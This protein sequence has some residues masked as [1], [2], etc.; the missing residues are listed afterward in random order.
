MTPKSISLRPI[1]INPIPSTSNAIPDT[2]E[3]TSEEELVP[4]KRMKL[5][6]GAKDQSTKDLKLELLKRKL[7]L[8]ERKI[9][10][11]EQLLALRKQ[12]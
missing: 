12:E 1:R 9:N 5:S 7:D 8:E 11:L 4:T 6:P 3:D 2:P 10:L